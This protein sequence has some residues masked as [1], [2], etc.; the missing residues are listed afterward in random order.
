MYTIEEFDK[1]KTKIMK[2]IMYKKRTEYEVKNKFQNTIQNDILCDI[3]EYVKEAGY[4][5]DEDYIN[6]A[7]LEFIN[8]KNISIREIEYKLQSKG[9]DKEKIEDYIYKNKDKLEEHELKSATNIVQKKKSLMNEEEIKM[10]LIKKGYS[11]EILK[12][13]LK[14]SFL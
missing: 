5:S 12:E 9:I 7:I 4:L 1:E 8:L 2:Y 14:E 11:K 6:K 13:A 3:I 10:Y